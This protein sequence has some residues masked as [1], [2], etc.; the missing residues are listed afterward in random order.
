MSELEQEALMIKNESS[1]LEPS[2]CKCSSTSRNELSKEED[3]EDD[4][5]P[6]LKVCM[7]QGN[8][9]GDAY[10]LSKIHDLP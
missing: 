10:M 3:A 6:K 4:P 2:I 5:I 1:F 7:A 9:E 8:L